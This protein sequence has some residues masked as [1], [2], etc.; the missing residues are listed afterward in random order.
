M[1]N[2]ETI[3]EVRTVK[4]TEL[5]NSILSIVKQIPR[6]EVEG[7]SMDAPSCTY[8]LEK[9]FL[10]WQQ[11]QDKKMYSEEDM[12]EAFENGVGSGKYQAEYGDNAKGSMNFKYFIKQFKNK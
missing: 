3:E 2:K 6:K 4:R 11:E 1:G 7:D 8:E 10:K 9:L 5:Y 12:R